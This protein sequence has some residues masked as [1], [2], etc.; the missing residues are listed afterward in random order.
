MYKI[1]KESPVTTA[2]E[3]DV[4]EEL[5][6]VRSQINQTNLT[7]DEDDETKKALLSLKT[8]STSNKLL[9]SSEVMLCEI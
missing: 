6:E 8:K 5:I 2:D 7:E 1:T 9:T 3:Y 4:G